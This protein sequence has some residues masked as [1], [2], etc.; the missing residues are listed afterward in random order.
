MNK[1]VH[2][3]LVLTCVCLGSAIGL[4]GTFVLTEG[5]IAARRKQKVAQA[6]QAVL[7]GAAQTKLLNPHATPED[8]VYAGLG[9]RGQTLGY[10]ATGSAQ[11]YSSKIAVMVGFGA[12]PF[13]LAIV[14]IRVIDQQETPGLGANIQ[15]QSTNKTLWTVFGLVEESPNIPLSFQGQF[16]K[17]V[18]DTLQLSKTPAPDKVLA[19]TGATISSAAVLRAVKAAGEKVREAAGAKVHIVPGRERHPVSAGTSR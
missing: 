18:L 17:Q 19:I 7:P 14:N 5:R 8:R 12:D 1:K 3:T 4:A 16:A 11:G 6:L 10:A 2:Y 13:K 9:E 15:K